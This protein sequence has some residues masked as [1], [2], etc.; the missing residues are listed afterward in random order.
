MATQRAAST[1]SRSTPNSRIRAAAWQAAS[2]SAAW[3]KM[4]RMPWQRWS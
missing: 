3:V 2:N 1:G 4:C